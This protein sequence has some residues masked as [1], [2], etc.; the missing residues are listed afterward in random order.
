MGPQRR[1]SMLLHIDYFI[2][3]WAN[4]YTDARAVADKHVLSRLP[5]CSHQLVF[6]L[7]ASKAAAIAESGSDVLGY[8]GIDVTL[9]GMAPRLSCGDER[10]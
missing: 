3:V 10:G 1:H 9:P 8:S 5:D 6:G 2:P 7:E 4:R